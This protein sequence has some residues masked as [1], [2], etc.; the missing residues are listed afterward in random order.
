MPRPSTIMPCRSNRICIPI[1]AIRRRPVGVSRIL[2]HRTPILCF[3]ATQKLSVRVLLGAPGR[4]QQIHKESKDVEGKDE[5]DDPF[6]NG[7]DVLFTVERGGREDDCKNDLHDNEYE[8]EPEGETQD[9]MLAEMHA[10]ALVLGADEDGADDVASDEQEE[11]AVVQ[12][13]VMESVEDGEEDQAAGS[14]DGEDD[15]DD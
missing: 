8:F 11:E 13:R 2:H 7:R 5:R 1:D 9:P 15:C 14:C 10:E 3:F 4:R 6:E 12:M